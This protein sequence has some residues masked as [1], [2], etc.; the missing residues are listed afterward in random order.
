MVA[1]SRSSGTFVIWW[2]PGAS[3]E[4]VIIGRAAFFDPLMATSPLRGFPPLIINCSMEFILPQQDARSQKSCVHSP[5]KTGI[6]KN[7]KDRKPD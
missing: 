4:A 1:T 2:T 5:D 6:I 7:G 3:S